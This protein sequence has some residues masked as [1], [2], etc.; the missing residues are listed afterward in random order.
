MPQEFGLGALINPPDERDYIAALYLGAPEVKPFDYRPQMGMPLNQG[1]TPK[2]VTHAHSIQEWVNEH[3][4]GCNNVLDPHRLYA[5]CKAEDGIPDAPGTYPRTAYDIQRRDGIAEAPY[6]GTPQEDANALTH[7][8]ASY[9]ACRRDKDSLTA[10]A[11]ASG[12]PVAISIPVYQ[13]LYDNIRTGIIP[14]PGGYGD[15]LRGY[16]RLLYSTWDPTTKYS[17]RLRNS[18]GMVGAEGDL[19][20]ED[21]VFDVLV[22]EAHT[23]VDMTT[24]ERPWADWYE[25]TAYAEGNAV[26]DSG[27]MK[28]FPDGNFYPAFDMTQHQVI[29]VARRASVPGLHDVDDWAKLATRGWVRDTFPGLTWVEE[30]WTEPITR[31]QFAMLLARR[32]A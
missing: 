23:I 18:W 16:H 15:V 13:S 25:N 5:K 10:A 4:Q 6:V 28:G 29:T 24:F 31:F 20:C 26:K 7:R 8:I 12:V 11:I 3:K 14:M 9:A 21:P 17:R 27:L 2:C 32:L 30:R 22:L 1:Q 19:I